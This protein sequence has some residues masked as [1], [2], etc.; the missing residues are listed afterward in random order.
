MLRLA[1]QNDS[2]ARFFAALGLLLMRFLKNVRQSL[3]ALF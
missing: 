2:G 1:P 3:E